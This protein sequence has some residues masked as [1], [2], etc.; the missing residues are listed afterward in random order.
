MRKLYAIILLFLVS[1]FAIRANAY[2]FSAT[3]NSGHTLYYTITSNES[4]YT[5]N[6]VSENSSSP[7]Y[8][9]NPT[10]DIEFPSS[11]VHD[12]IT[13][14]V[15][16]FG[17]NAF[18]GCSGL[19]SVTIPSTITSFD[20]WAFNSCTGLTAVYYTGSL[21]EWCRID[22]I[23]SVQTNPLYY[24]NRLYINN[25]LITD[26]V[27]PNTITEVKARSFSGLSAI[28]SLT[29]PN[30]V[31]SIG[32]EAFEKCSGLQSITV[33]S[34]NAAYDSRDNCNAI[35]ETATNSLVVGCRNTIIPNSVT[36]IGDDAFSGCTGLTSITIPNSVTSIGDDAFFNCAGLASITI[37]DNV[38]SIGAYAFNGCSS[39]SSITFGSGLTSIGGFAFSMTPWRDNQP[40]GLLYVG[41]CCI[42]YK[43][44]P[45]ETV[46][47]QEG[48]LY[49]TESSFMYQSGITNMI[50]PNSLISIGKNAFYR[51]HI[52]TVTI[53]E[54]VEIIDYLAFYEC[55][56]LTTVN[57]NAINCTDMA[58]SYTPAFK[59]C[60]SLTT[61]NIG[62]RVKS[63]PSRAFEDCSSLTGD[64]I[65]P[66][67]VTNIGMDAFEGC[68]G[69]TSVT[70]GKSVE[71]MGGSAFWGC[72]GI[73]T[74]NFNATNCT[75][76]NSDF[77]HCTML[78]TMN[79]GENVTRIPNYAFSSCSG[80]TSITIPD[81][82]TYIG[83]YAFRDC[84]GL[85]S[86]TIPE[87]VA[88]MGYNV[89]SGCSNL[90]TVNFNA[91]N[92]TSMGTSTGSN[93]FVDSQITTF[94][95]GENVTRIPEYAFYGCE[96][97]TDIY[98]HSITPPTLLS[99]S[100]FASAT[101]SNA[102]VW[103]PC[104]AASTYRN[105]NLWSYFANIQ[106]EQAT[107]FNIAVQSADANMGDVVGDGSF[108]CDTEVTITA[109]PNDGYRFVAWNDGNEDNPR[110]ITV[111]GDSTFVA[112][113]RAIHTITASAGDHGAISPSGDI[114]LD[115]GASQTYIITPDN[116]YQ[117]ASVLVDDVEAIDE[118]VNGTYTFTGLAANHTIVAIFENGLQTITVVA[119]EHGTITHDATE[120][121]AV[122]NCGGSQSFTIIP[123][124]C[125]KIGDV[126]VDGVTVR[127]D[128]NNTYTFQNV[129]EDH[130]IEAAFAILTYTISVS[131]GEHGAI[132]HNNE[133][134]NAV[135]NCGGN[136][137]FIIMPETYY[138][139]AS[140]I[141]DGQ[142]DVTDL[143]V[144][145]VYTFE[146]VT[147]SHTI[148]AIFEVNTYTISA[149]VNNEEFG[150]V[151]G[152]GTYDAGTEISLTATPNDGYRFVS[153]NDGN[154]DNPRTLIVTS[155]SAFVA[156]FVRSQF[157]ITVLSS[158]SNG[159]SVTGGG[160]YPES[161][162]ATLTATPSIGYC[163]ISWN[164]GSTD[165]PRM[166][167]VVQDS[168]FIAEFSATVHRAVDTTVT[169]YL[170]IDE[171]TF[172]VSGIYS[173]VKLSDEACDTIV[174]LTL[175]VLDEPQT[176][177]ISPN[178][179]KS[180]INISSEDY[181]S[182]VE[183]YSTAGW[184]VMH[185]EINA[186]QAEINVE[187]LV[188]GVY[189]VRLYGEDGHVPS[190]QRFVKE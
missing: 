36:S 138:H 17:R 16:G 132:A 4:P 52:E 58:V 55:L 109:T 123:D 153:W 116:C 150:Y 158:D 184:L 56:E 94:H 176:Y 61:L 177:D 42:G 88:S 8:T 128:E 32:E 14:S 144:D 66:D 164:D 140:V 41:P 62:E 141:V 161:D 139:I 170:S 165:N 178:P 69:L 118:L 101:Y 137:S 83:N 152:D 47:I 120:G 81:S 73:T 122:V 142:T 110:T 28:T 188:S 183:I 27:I 166:V 125:Y 124:N 130:T 80:L 162:T 24:A 147:E 97:V 49:I 26:L 45:P 39:L 100:A 131:A 115:E 167:E 163:F 71:T 13:Y 22:F 5:V 3:C 175:R 181:I 48:T 113:F 126:I 174:D 95:I 2:D 44:T 107:V 23:I 75:S 43:G 157:T 121:D 98:V 154:T 57:F 106:N 151:N 173:Y 149:T 108:T 86:I 117:I 93:A 114:T 50:I 20:Y 145:G 136:Q 33:D 77:S 85:T 82:V 189:F 1:L 84:S 90:T 29:I 160:T 180:L 78:T 96:T 92:C 54:S 79:I 179:A 21:E 103:T 171:H 68:T 111:G 72:E 156:T 38:T 6:I 119:G 190:V 59:N 168:T 155:D 159:G 143:L 89:F 25:V 15:T 37:P 34:N 105:A 46:S 10:G 148:S 112:S 40:D 185:K 99:Y 9:T 30:S 53:G 18:D 74:V 186:Y 31:T 35:I 87:A 134:G 67:S 19:T 187:G 146:N 65:I 104:P 7:Y 64:L 169:S 12:G 133:D 63:I 60:S 129:T 172:Y 102:T 135:V 127:L 11:V 182:T 91:T 76:M 51:S 70:I